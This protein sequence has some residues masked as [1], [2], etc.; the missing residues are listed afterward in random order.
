MPKY[1]LGMLQL[2][3]N[4]KLKFINISKSDTNIQ[5]DTNI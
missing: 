1:T 2:F 5:T 4:K 3:K